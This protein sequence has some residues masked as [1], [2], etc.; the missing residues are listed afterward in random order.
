MFAE[1]QYQIRTD[2]V[3]VI[4]AY[5]GCVYHPSVGRLITGL[6]EVENSSPAQPYKKILAPSLS[7]SDSFIGS[8]L[9]GQ[10]EAALPGH[11]LL[12]VAAA[13]IRLCE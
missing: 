13:S 8:S 3:M 9:S 12:V 10:V 5:H 4:S 11:Y 1:C 2:F 6:Y 7:Q